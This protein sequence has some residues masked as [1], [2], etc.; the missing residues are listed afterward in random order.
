[1]RGHKKQGMYGS[2]L[3]TRTEKKL[4]KD[5]ESQAVRKFKTLEVW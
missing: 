2:I 1:V 4:K 3:D 5:T